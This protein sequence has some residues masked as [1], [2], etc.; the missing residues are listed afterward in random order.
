MTRVKGSPGGLFFVSTTFYKQ[1]SPG[2]RTAVVVSRSV[3]EY[4]N[5]Q[6][7]GGSSI[8]DVLVLVPFMHKK[9]IPSP[10]LEQCALTR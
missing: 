9:I 5:H 1:T 6:F 7:F 2:Y 4:L 8:L 3:S 10:E